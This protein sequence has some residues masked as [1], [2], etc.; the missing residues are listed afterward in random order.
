LDK[1][2]GVGNAAGTG[3]RMALLN[4]GYRREI[5]ELVR[6]IE[7]VETAIEPRFQEH[8]VSAMAFPNKREPFPNLAA[9][10]ELPKR[11]EQISDAGHESRRR[12]RRTARR[13]AE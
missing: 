8:F 1:V 6:R 7:K 9:T 2:A 13:V 3:A 11:A 10:V 12:G 5:E 4:K